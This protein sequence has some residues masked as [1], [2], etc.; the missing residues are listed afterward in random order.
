[1]TYMIITDNERQLDNAAFW[2]FCKELNIKH[3]CSS[4]AHLQ[5]NKQVE[6]V[7]KIIKRN[8]NTQVEGIKG[9]WAKNFLVYCG[10]TGQHLAPRLGNPFSLSFG[11]KAVVPVEIGIPFPIVEQFDV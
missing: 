2:N 3:I 9:F 11:F 1:M 6:E 10:R 5:A 7:N 4:P 8:L